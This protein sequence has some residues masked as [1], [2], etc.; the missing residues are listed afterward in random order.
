MKFADT[1]SRNAR[2]DAVMADRRAADA[3]FSER[4]AAHAVA[5]Y[6]A[7]G[8][9]ETIAPLPTPRRYRSI[10]VNIKDA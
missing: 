7:Q 1:R 4:D 5:D 2:F 8:R 6:I 10:V 9:A 3:K